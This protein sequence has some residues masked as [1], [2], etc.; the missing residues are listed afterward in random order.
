MMKKLLVIEKLEVPDELAVPGIFLDPAHS[1]G[2]ATKRLISAAEIGRPE[3]MA[4]FQE[5]RAVQRI[6]VRL[7]G[8]DDSSLVVDEVRFFRVHRAEERVA[9]KG[10]RLIDRQA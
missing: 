1:A 8:V 4:V 3:Q 5:V 2:T 9:W 10:T 6:G 7:P